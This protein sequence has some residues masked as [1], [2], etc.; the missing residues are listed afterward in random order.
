[1]AVLFS[2]VLLLLQSFWTLLFAQVTN[3]RLT[4]CHK[5]VVMFQHF[6]VKFHDSARFLHHQLGLD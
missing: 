2:L 1:M 3:T 4:P 5:A 6:Y